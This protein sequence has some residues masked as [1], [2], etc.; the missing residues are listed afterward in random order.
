MQY[1]PAVAPALSF[2]LLLGCKWMS[3]KS[4][5]KPATAEKAGEKKDSDDVERNV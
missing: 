4:K 5:Q 1:I 3:T 2:F